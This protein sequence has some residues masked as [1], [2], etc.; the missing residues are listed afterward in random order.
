MPSVLRKKSYGSVKV[1]WLDRELALSQA[2]AAARRL[3]AER[4]D[5]QRVGIF[6]SIA[7]G[8]AVPGSDLDVLLVLSHSDQRPIDRPAGFLA[9]FDEVGLP[10]ELF[11]F[12]EEEACGSAFFTRN[13]ADALWID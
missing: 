10:T 2:I 6:G 9:Y 12:T 3:V 4:A 7:T 8:R 13:A 5:V 1:F 11:C